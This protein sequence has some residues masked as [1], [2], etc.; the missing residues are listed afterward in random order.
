MMNWNGA[1]CRCFEKDITLIFLG[2]MQQQRIKPT[3]NKEIPKSNPD[4]ELM[5]F[6]NAFYK[7]VH[8]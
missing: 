2:R 8:V 5:I 3:N 1:T 4:T 6:N 7:L